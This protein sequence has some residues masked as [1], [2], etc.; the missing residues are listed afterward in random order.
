[1]KMKNNWNIIGHKWAVDLL[2][3]SL[4]S[5][6][7]RHAYLFTGPQGIGRRT[8][9][10]R[11]AQAINCLHETT[12]EK[13]CGECRSCRL[14]ES[15][16]H[17]DLSIVKSEVIG[18][19]LKIDQ[20]RKLHHNLSLTPYEAKFRIALI[21]RFEEANQNAANALL[22]TLEEPPPQVLMLLTA[23][24][25]E[26]L[27]PTILSRCELIRLRPLP[28]NTLAIG[29]QERFGIPYERATTLAHI[30]EGRPGSALHYHH[31]PDLMNKRENWLNDLLSLIS[32]KR[33]DRFKYADDVSK[34]KEILEQLLGVWSSFWRDILMTTVESNVFLSNIDFK[35]NIYTIASKVEHTS[36]VK[37]VNTINRTQKLIHQN[38]NTKMAMEILLL[39]LPFL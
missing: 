18:G 2:R 22:K 27:L 36:A 25:P 37:M 13:P 38:V 32:A 14:F 20:I 17:P 12:T 10:S 35:D 16:Q 19:V 23:Q 7:I 30:A 15:M 3:N 11:Y 31:N 6:R 28:I 1:M 33:V 26:T 29:L 9:A 24:E 8:L 4:I 34:D 39:D 21:L 5:R